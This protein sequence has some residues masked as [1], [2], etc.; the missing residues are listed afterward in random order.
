MIATALLLNWKRPENLERIIE[1]IK[2]Q[3][4]PIK[5]FLWNNNIED[6]RKYPVDLQIDSSINL[7]CS[8]RWIMAGYADTDYV[9]SLDDDLTLKDNFVI[10][11]CIKYVSNNNCAIGYSGVILN[12]KKEYCASKHIESNK[13]DDII[14]D[15][16]K[17]RFIFVKRKDCIAVNFSAIDKTHNF[18]IEDDIILSSYLNKKIIPSFL[19]ERLNNLPGKYA[20]CSMPDHYQSRILITKKYFN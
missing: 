15:I 3:S 10:E 9:F 13:T 11:D 4:V 6:K 17:G 16:I 8:P 14:V 5:I 2:K 20:L 12:N 7:M 1:D 19:Y 18:R